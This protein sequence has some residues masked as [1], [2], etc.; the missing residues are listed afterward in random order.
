MKNIDK[1]IRKLEKQKWLEEEEME[2]LILCYDEILKSGCCNK[3]Q[4][5]QIKQFINKHIITRKL[6]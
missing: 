6:I 2:E 1:F 4:E 3:E 5:E